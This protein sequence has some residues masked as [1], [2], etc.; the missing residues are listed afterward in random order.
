MSVSSDNFFKIYFGVHLHFTSEKYDFLKYTGN[1]TGL[2]LAKKSYSSIIDV[3]AKKIDSL[4]DALEICVFN[5]LKNEKWLFNSF[6]ESKDVMLAGKK[7]FSTYTRAL[8]RD[9]EYINKLMETK[10]LSITELI[11]P[12]RSGNKPPLL[13]AHLNRS[14]SIIGICSYDSEYNF[15]SDW[16]CKFPNDPLVVQKCIKLIKFKPFIK[17]LRGE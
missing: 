17:I 15:L 7:I 4:S 14:I 3:Y 1:I 2:D 8:E 5:E 6:E 10:H 11:Q 16:K 9:Y 13:Q 12:T